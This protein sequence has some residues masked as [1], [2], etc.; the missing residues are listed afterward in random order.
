VNV[1]MNCNDCGKPI[2][3]KKD[4]TFRMHNG[5]EY[6][7]MWGRTCSGAGRKPAEDKADTPPPTLT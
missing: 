1:R 2:L 6:D 7:G 5:W 3:L 4:G